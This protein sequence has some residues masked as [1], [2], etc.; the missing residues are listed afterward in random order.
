MLLT[1]RPGG[2]CWRDPSDRSPHDLAQ[3]PRAWRAG[4]EKSCADVKHGAGSLN[5]LA[6][7]DLHVINE[8]F[9]LQG[10][11]QRRDRSHVETDMSLDEAS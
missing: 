8:I 5:R 2:H 4:P 3:R 7:D 9:A 11:A 10:Q 1:Q 6:P